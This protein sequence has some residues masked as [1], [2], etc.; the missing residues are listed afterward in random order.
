[1][2]RHS[3]AVR[4]RLRWAAAAIVLLVADVRPRAQSDPATSPSSPEFFSGYRFH[5]NAASLASD[6]PRFTWD[7]NFGGDI[8]LVDYVRGRLNF[9][10]NYQVVLGEQLRAFDPNQANYTLDFSSSYRFGSTEVAAVFHHLSRHLGDR[11][12]S[13]PIDWNALGARVVR[14]D[15]RRRLRL[16]S[17]AQIEKIVKRSFVDYRWQLSGGAGA[18]FPADSRV[19]AITGGSLTFIGT[20]PALASRDGVLAAY[21]EGGIRITGG[22]GA[23]ELFVA[24]ER[25]VDAHPLDR[26]TQSWALFGFRLVNR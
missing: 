24:V 16:E 20:D 10:A 9:L 6:D 5:L 25:R 1:M 23:A 13:F 2:P 15:T 3:R 14:R 8:D 7:A 22:A 4:R 26:S 19:A 21:G 17:R 12:K 11:A 18:R